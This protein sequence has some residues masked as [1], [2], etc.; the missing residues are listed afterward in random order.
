MT[1]A[2]AELQE[3]DSEED[4]D[5]GSGALHVYPIFGKAHVTSWNCWCRPHTE[6]G[7]NGHPIWVHQVYH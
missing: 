1:V 7:E 6:W 3:D 5:P 2:V 4:C